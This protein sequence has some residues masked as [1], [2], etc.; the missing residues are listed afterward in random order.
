MEITPVPSRFFFDRNDHI[1]LKMVNDV[2]K[3]DAEEHDVKDLLASHLH[4]HGIKEM[5]ASTGLRIAYA[6]I[7]LLGS[8]EVGMASDRKNALRALRDE[9]FCNAQKGSLHK[10]TA[11]VL[12]EI[13]K[14]LVRSRGDYIRQLQLARDFRMA[15]FGKP[16]FIRG[17]LA[18]HHLVE[19]PED[20]NQIAFDDHV[21]DAN[22]KG[23]KSP[24][25]MIMDAWIK[26]IR[27][28]NVIYYNYIDMEVAEELM[29]SA[30]IMGISVRVGIEYPVRFRGRYIKLFLVPRGF[31]DRQSFVDFLNREVIR[32]FMRKG[33]QVS[34]YQQRYVFSALEAFNSRHRP[35]I[36]EAYGTSL[37]PISGEEFLAFVGTGQ[38]S[39]LHLARYIY[40]RLSPEIQ[41]AVSRLRGEYDAGDDEERLRIRH[42]LDVMYALDV[43]AIS[44]GFL[45]PAKN[46][47]IHNPFEP[48]DGPDIPEL[49]QL[50]PDALLEQIAALNA[51]VRVTLNLT[52]LSSADVLE[53]LY[54]CK[55]RITHLEIF[56]LKDHTSGEGTHNAEINRLQL[57]IN[58]G[59]MIKLKRIINKIILDTETGAD[60]AEVAGRLS[61]LTGILHDMPTLQGYYRHSPLMSRFGTDSTGS[62][63]NHF[64]MGFVIKDTLPLR[65]RRI[66]DADPL[67]ERVRIPVKMTAMLRVT[68]IPRKLGHHLGAF[69]NLQP[70][71]ANAL[72]PSSG[73]TGYGY[74]V[75]RDWVVHSYS[76]HMG[77]RGNLALLG[78][79]QTGREVRSLAPEGDSGAGCRIPLRYL[80]THLKNALKILV[81]FI[82]AFATFFLT[83][84]WWFLAYFGAFIWF[85]ITGARNILQSVLG[86]GGIRRSPLLRWNDYISWDRLAESLLYTGFSVPLLDFLVKTMLMDRMFGVTTRNSPLILYAVM[87]LANGI[88]ISTHNFFRGLPRQVVFGNF[89]RSVLSIPL[90]VILN[91]GIGLLLGMAGTAAVQPVLQKWAAVI[92]KLASDC[93]AAII[94]GLADRLTNI[95]MRFMDYSTKIAQ[96]FDVFS[97]LEVLFPEADVIALLESP[98]DFLRV[99]GEKQP[100]LGKIVIINALD[101]LYI[102]MYQPRAGSSL[103]TIMRS[104]NQ[105]ERR[106]LIASQ[107]ILTQQR[108]ISQLFVDE[109]FG[110]KFSRALSFYLE[111]SEDYLSA[112]ET[113]YARYQI[114]EARENFRKQ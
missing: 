75:Q 28:L 93:V 69:E 103:D 105:D 31:S 24:T 114:H 46:P 21:H 41:T 43:D 45:Q 35:V 40:T 13:M 10:N 53:I 70:G 6:V 14:E 110:K 52:G 111:R 8:L 66:L 30:E 16:R 82:P 112:L 85:G 109:V 57:A 1:L 32:D 51:G 71:P 29:E 92:S 59:N 107:Y 39:L 65:S 78:G 23:R 62:S 15:T 79:I 86:G 83:K 49:A 89:F 84:D 104:M 11:R 3:P 97:R 25:H 106:I 91:A 18:K 102:W 68:Y 12:I 33:R 113:M 77:P 2:L 74:E 34:E 63:R 73:T 50:G 4:P 94:E 80:N 67:Q 36:N 101:L 7:H 38:P 98:Q 88:Y 54:D 17:Q 22:T 100:D 60:P 96:V 87:A 56:N 44:E 9:V 95:R 26:G 61:K 64:G 42:A 90:A 37:A 19:M 76:A 20:W 48:Q 55:G 99:V 27:S 81:G 5:T 58:Q 72:P 47:D 108:Q